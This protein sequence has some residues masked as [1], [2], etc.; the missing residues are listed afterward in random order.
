[1]EN[2]A[3]IA[4]EDNLKYINPASDPVMW[5]LN[6]ALLAMAQQQYEMN[7]RLK[8]LEKHLVHPLML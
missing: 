2:D 6:K 8:K 4:L 5:N 3:V 7:Q 1:M